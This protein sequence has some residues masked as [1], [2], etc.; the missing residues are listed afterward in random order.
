MRK[1]KF[2][3]GVKF[4]LSL[5]IILFVPLVIKQF[6]TKQNFNPYRPVRVGGYAA[7]GTITIVELPFVLA[8]A[9]EQSIAIHK[10]SETKVV[11]S[12]IPV[13]KK[14]FL[15]FIPTVSGWQKS[16]IGYQT[17]HYITLITVC[18]RLTPG[19]FLAQ[20]LSMEKFP[21]IFV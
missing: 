14:D 19:L 5:A 6:V 7:D 12:F 20:H 21:W 2:S 4:A 1:N 18:Y 16:I 3:R 11:Y 10:L 17:F 9:V 13:D 8:N 15:K